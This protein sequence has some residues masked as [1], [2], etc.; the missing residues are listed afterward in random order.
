M[1]LL[2]DENARLCEVWLANAQA[3]QRLLRFEISAKN[4]RLAQ[5]A[6]KPSKAREDFL[7]DPRAAGA[8]PAGPNKY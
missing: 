7:F 5:R 6:G 2:A 4:G 3:P 8:V 1:A